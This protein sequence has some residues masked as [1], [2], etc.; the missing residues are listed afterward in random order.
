M[1]NQEIFLTE[2]KCDKT[3]DKC[4]TCLSNKCKHSPEYCVRSINCDSC[5]D[6]WCLCNPNF[7]QKEF[8]KMEYCQQYEGVI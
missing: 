8:N 2:N 4:K 6:Y 7:D 3:I 5:T 1:I